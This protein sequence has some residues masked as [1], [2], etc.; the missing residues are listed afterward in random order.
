M[1]TLTLDVPMSRLT[2]I[3]LLFILWHLLL[4]LYHTGQYMEQQS[5]L[6][7]L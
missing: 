2:Y 7:Y 6:Y 5:Q 4:Y 3:S 1:M